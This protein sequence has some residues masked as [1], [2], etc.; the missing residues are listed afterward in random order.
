MPLSQEAK[1]A[2]NKMY[3]EKHRDHL[4]AYKRERYQ[5]NKIWVLEQ[6][7]QKRKQAKKLQ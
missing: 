6:E 5:D 1:K 7:K 3:R 2:Y 4:L